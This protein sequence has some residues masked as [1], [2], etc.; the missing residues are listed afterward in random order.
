M[1]ELVKIRKKP[2]FGEALS[3]TELIVKRHV[4]QGLKNAEV[5][6]LMF[7]CEKTIK[8]HLTYIYK[9]LGVKG[10]IQMLLQEY[11]TLGD[12]DP[13][14]TKFAINR[15]KDQIGKDGP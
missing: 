8:G 14:L 7:T 1:S 10:R 12:A 9:K 15:M 5:A 6:R 4:L 3:K 2:Q 11:T 13:R